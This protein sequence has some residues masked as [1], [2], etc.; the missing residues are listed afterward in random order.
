[1]LEVSVVDDGQRLA[2]VGVEEEEEPAE[3][4]RLGAVL[5]L[6]APSVADVPPA[7]DVR[8]HPNHVAMEPLARALHRSPAMESRRVVRLGI[9]VDAR[10]RDQL[11]PR[12]LPVPIFQDA[13]RVLDGKHPLDV[14]VVEEEHAYRLAAGANAPAVSRRGVPAFPYRAATTSAMMASAISSGAWDPMSSPIGECTAASRSR[15][16]PRARSRCTRSW[17][18]LRLPMAP[19]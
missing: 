11:V 2:G 15:S 5:V 12:Q 19:M 4:A 7:N 1:M 9:D 6:H 16:T 13:E 17:F 8:L 10:P 3:E 14:V 18:V